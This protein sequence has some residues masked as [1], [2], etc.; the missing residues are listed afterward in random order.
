MSNRRKL[1]DCQYFQD[2]NIVVIQEILNGNRNH[3]IIKDPDFHY[4]IEPELKQHKKETKY[5]KEI[6]QLK[7]VDCKYKDRFLSVAKELGIEIANPAAIERDYDF[8]KRLLA[9]H[10]LYSADDSIEFRTIVKYFEDYKDEID[11][12][13]P[14]NFMFFDIEVH[15]DFNKNIYLELEKAYEHLEFNKPYNPDLSNIYMKPFEYIQNETDLDKVAGYIKEFALN[16]SK[17][18]YFDIRFYLA[19]MNSKAIEIDRD[20]VVSYLRKQLTKTRLEYIYSNIG[21]P[22]EEKANNRIDAISFVDSKNRKLYMYLLK[23]EN[24]LESQED[25][26]YINNTSLVNTELSNFIELFNI[27]SFLTNIDNKEKEI[28]KE[29]LDNLDY[30]TEMYKSIDIINDED[31]IKVN[32]LIE[33]ARVTIPNYDTRIKTTVEYVLF[34]NELDMILSFFDKVKNEIKPNIIAAHNA[35]FDINTLKNRLAK[36]GVDFNKQINQLT[37]YN[38]MD[39]DNLQSKI[40]IDLLTMEKK[41]DKTRYFC[42]GVTIVDTLL[43]YAKTASKEKNWSLDAIVQEELKDSK[44]PYKFEIFEF[45]MKD[46]RRFIKYSAVDTM[47]LLRLEEVLKF[48]ELFQLILANSKTEWNSYMYRTMYL[49]NMIKYELGKRK[50]GYFVLRDNLTSLNPRKEKAQGSVKEV[51]YDGAYNTPVERVCGNGLHTNLYDLDFSSFYPS[52]SI[53]TN[54]CVDVLKFSTEDKTMHNDYLFKSR[55]G[56]GNKYFNLPSSKEIYDE[57]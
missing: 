28:C 47:L 25:I 32:S 36:Y 54:I 19:L 17:H 11:D 14:I 29:L 38:D 39:L 8:R 44:I 33:K 12:S 37:V 49:T 45:Y 3:I 56:L 9:D 52:C 31:K 50:D 55:I 40:K 48:I 51:A 34:D 23:I 16:V 43:L 42:P 2:E 22:D 15:A 5:Y 35:K 4:Y 30:L 20:R 7:R 13:L 46:I 18:K 10:N 27:V 21:F 26:N 6:S 1:I 53:T 57:I 24:D 41:K